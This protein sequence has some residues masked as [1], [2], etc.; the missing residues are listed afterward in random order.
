MLV[1]IRFDPWNVPEPD[2]RV[3]PGDRPPWSVQ[4]GKGTNRIWVA[5]FRNSS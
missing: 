1:L 5:H 2:A 3:T 4:K